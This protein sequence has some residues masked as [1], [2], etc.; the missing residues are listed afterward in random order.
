M[1]ISF[2]REAGAVPSVAVC[3]PPLRFRFSDALVAEQE[4]DARFRDEYDFSQVP[5]ISPDL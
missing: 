3:S 4:L 2:L 5:S 1:T